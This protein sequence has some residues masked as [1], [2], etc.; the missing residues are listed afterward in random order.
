MKQDPMDANFFRNETRETPY[1]AHVRRANL[2]M[3]D[4][5]PHAAL[6]QAEQQRIANL[7]GLSDIAQRNGGGQVAGLAI[8]QAAV[9]LG[10]I[11]DERPVTDLAAWRTEV[12]DEAAIDIKHHI[13]EDTIEEYLGNLKI[14]DAGLPAYGIRKVANAAAQVARARA[15]R[16]DPVDLTENLT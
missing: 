1:A 11:P 4:D 10:L 3:I 7:I 13:V 9:A 16:R 15:S 8:H 12:A 5:N 14:D 6:A 2:S